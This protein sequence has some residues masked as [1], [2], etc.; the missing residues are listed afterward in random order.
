[1][2]WKR[3]F[4]IGFGVLLWTASSLPQKPTWGIEHRD[5]FLVAPKAKNVTY[6]VST[7]ITL[8]GPSEQDDMTY[9]VEEPYPASGFI[10]HL[11]DD[12]K[13]R[14]WTPDNC[15]NCEEKWVEQPERPRSE[16][17]W[18]AGWHNGNNDSIHYW[19]EYKNAKNEHYLRTLHVLAEFGAAGPPQ[20]PTSAPPVYSSPRT[21]LK[22]GM[23]RGGLI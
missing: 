6:K 5:S 19:L 12:L 10:H 7:Y 15:Q 22:D 4:V 16:Y 18:I 1:M 9:T 13:L 11:N 21:T 14:G 3:A 20:S 2:I 23:V 8:G 17:L